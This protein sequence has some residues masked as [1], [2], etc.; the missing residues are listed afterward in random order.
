MAKLSF[1][2]KKLNGKKSDEMKTKIAAKEGECFKNA[3]GAILQ[4]DKS[5]P[6]L[7]YVEGFCVDEKPLVFIHGWLEDENN[8]YDVTLGSKTNG[9]REYLPLISITPDV[10]L[11]NLKK[12]KMK[13]AFVIRTESDNF[14][15]LTTAKLLH[16]NGYVNAGL[17]EIMTD[18]WINHH[19]KKLGK[20]E[21]QKKISLIH[22][23]NH[24]FLPI[25][26]FP[27]SLYHYVSKM[28]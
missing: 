23:Y 27:P 5:I 21:F 15:A 6:G 25:P 20:A 9:K 13:D 17:G 22:P 26:Q 28:G 18:K 24:S 4:F 8:I 14:L 10:M 1:S 19:F 7:I 12:K 2:P 3:M 11:E 16:H